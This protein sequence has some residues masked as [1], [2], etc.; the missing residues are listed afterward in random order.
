MSIITYN[1]C[2]VLGK[3]EKTSIILKPPIFNRGA[4]KYPRLTSIFFSQHNIY[5]LLMYCFE[6]KIDVI[7]DCVDMPAVETAGF[8]MID[9]LSIISQYLWLMAIV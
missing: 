4:K 8:K 7:G 2:Q 6:N 3:R 1:W 9:A 5:G